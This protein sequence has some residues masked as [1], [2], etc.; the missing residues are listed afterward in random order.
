MSKTELKSQGNENALRGAQTLRAGCSKAE[1]KNRPS[2]DPLPGGAGRPKF[3]QLE[4]VTTK[5]S[6]SGSAPNTAS[7]C[8]M[9]DFLVYDSV[10][11]LFLQVSMFVC[12]E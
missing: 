2:A 1:P 5:Q 7:L 9:A 11:I 4:I 6:Y 12:W 10:Q 3:N 8:V